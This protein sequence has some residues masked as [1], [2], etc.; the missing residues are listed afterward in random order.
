[1]YVEKISF[2]QKQT[3]CVYICDMKMI[4]TNASQ[5]IAEVHSTS[6]WQ[7]FLS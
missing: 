7:L 5:C 2:L 3:V 6:A 1:M 4:L